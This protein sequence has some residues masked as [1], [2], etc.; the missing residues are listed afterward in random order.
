MR[1]A[2]SAHE[3]FA[4]MARIALRRASTSAGD[5]V[6]TRR[7]ASTNAAGESAI[8]TTSAYASATSRMRV[9]TIGFSAAMYSST[10]VG[11]M[12]RVASLSANGIRQTS[13]DAINEGSSP[14]GFMPR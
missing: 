8:S 12:N 4:T 11:L 5:A 13:H 9:L 14:Y 6:S 7:H 1:A 3:V 10:F 2:V